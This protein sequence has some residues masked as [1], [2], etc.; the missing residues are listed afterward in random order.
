MKAQTPKVG[1]A[2]VLKG[3]AR[4][5]THIEGNRVDFGHPEPEK[6]WSK[7]KWLAAQEERRQSGQVGEPI[8]MFEPSR[9]GACALNELRWSEANA[10]WYLE[11]Q[12][13]PA[14]QPDRK[15]DVVVPDLAALSA[16]GRSA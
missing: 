2:L 3:I 6:H 1:D 8:P 13:G 10:C 15:P 12:F 11:R 16:K 4:R 7:A 9:N 5:I 14:E